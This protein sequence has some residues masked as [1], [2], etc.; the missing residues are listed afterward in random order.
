MSY[1]KGVRTPKSLNYQA[2]SGIANIYI[3]NLCLFL[4][5]LLPKDG[6]KIEKNMISTYVLNSISLES[7]IHLS[8]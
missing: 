3:Y 4:L 5:I 8:F 2:A 1:F 6:N 7:H